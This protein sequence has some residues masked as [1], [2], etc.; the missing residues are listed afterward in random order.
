MK[1]EEIKIKHNLEWNVF[2]A[3][4]NTKQVRVVNVFNHMCFFDAVSTL[5]NSC[6]SKQDFSIKLDAV[7]RRYFWSKCEYELILDSFP[8]RGIDTKI[9][10]YAQLRL[11]WDAFVNYLWC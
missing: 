10:V 4:F 2:Y 5:L 11:N 6:S 8:E 9:D 1:A 3:D 7:A